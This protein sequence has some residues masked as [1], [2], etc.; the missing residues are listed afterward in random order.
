MHNRREDSLAGSPCLLEEQGQVSPP[1]FLPYPPL[2]PSRLWEAK[3]RE[4][5]LW[6]YSQGFFY[7][8][9]NLADSAH[10]P[11]NVFSACVL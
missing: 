6:G 5:R 9:P 4:K 7:I 11:E 1:P 10:I 3:N 2:C 8:K